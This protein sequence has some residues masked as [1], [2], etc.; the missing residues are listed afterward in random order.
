[1]N[2][3]TDTIRLLI[4]HESQDEAE[5]LINLLRN[6]GHATRATQITSEEEFI[7]QLKQHTWDLLLARPEADGILADI[8]ISHIRRMEKDIPVILL[9]DDNNSDF[10]TEGLKSGASDVVPME[11]EQ[12]FILVIKRELKNLAERRGRRKAEI[13]LREAEKRCDLLLDS[14]RDAITYVI[15][16]MHIYAN[17]SYIEMFGYDDPDDFEGMPMIDMVAPSD[18]D[19]LK[20]F[21]KS[22]TETESGELTCKGVRTDDSEISLK[23]LFSP[24]NYD[25]EPC[26]QIVIRAATGDAQLQEKLQE[27]SSQDLL[28]SLYNR[29]HFITKLDS[30]VQKATEGSDHYVLFYLSLDN[31]G[32]LK[33]QVGIA[34]A[35]LVLGDIA[36]LLKKEAVEEAILARFGEDVFT[37]VYPQDDPE[38][39]IEY[40]KRICSSIENHLS[41]VQD[42]SAQVTASIGIAM[43]N[44]SSPPTDELISR[45]HL[46]SDK[47]HE[48][49]QNGNGVHL[50][51]ID[52]DEKDA[53]DGQK[54]R[55][56]AQLQKA[57]DGGLFK[58]LFQPIISLRGDTSEFYEVL[59]RLIDDNGNDVS[60]HNFLATAAINK[61]A[62]KIDRWV[63]IQSVKT[64]VERRKKGVDTH[65]IINLTSQTLI[66]PT[67]LPWLS[68][69]LKAAR[70]PSDVL[71][72]QISESDATTYLK[73]AKAFTKGMTQLHCTTC[74]SRFGG[75]INPFNTLKHITV[76]YLKIDGSFLQDIDSQEAKETLKELVS[77]AHSHGKLT[78]MPMVES[79]G[80]LSSLWQIGVNYIQGYYLQPPLEQ[81]NYDF[82][83]EE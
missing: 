68:V 41:E 83:H 12:R 71:T 33:S 11:E 42:R 58:I 16:G 28:T 51:T 5:Q 17:Q 50:H 59:L 69:A 22:Y 48:T 65:I 44:E 53:P 63:I 57:I 24:A 21:L 20:K 26:T 66:D 18:Q 6:S 43:L 37:L 3:K 73:Q 36:T 2:R 38:L 54:Q 31:F 40:A 45:A 1:M 23:M 13:A 80:A 34:G 70:L 75:S 14:S 32:K 47:V 81:M 62:E 9:A 79:A 55:S 29:Q 25:G 56:K 67:F 60:P 4:L 8:A 19:N 7:D 64:L 27:I 49:N 76:D 52:D 10:L 61:L 35:D 78:I 30:C 15:D 82:S 46:A 74:I 72:F 77:T 39:A